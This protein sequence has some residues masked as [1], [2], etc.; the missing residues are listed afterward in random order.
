LAVFDPTHDKPLPIKARFETDENN[1]AYEAI[2]PLNFHFAAQAKAAPKVDG[3]FDDWTLSESL[4]LAANCEEHLFRH[5]N[6]G[7]W[8][9][10]EEFSG[11]LW[12]QWDVKNLYLA[13]RVH[14]SGQ[15]IAKS[16]E[17]L[18]AGDSIE[19]LIA[20]MGGRD[21]NSPYTQIAL[22]LVEGGQ[23]TVMRYQ[24]AGASGPLAKAQAVV[25]RV[26]GGYVYEA[27][28]PWAD[29]TADEAFAPK[30]GQAVTAVFGFNDKDAGTRMMSWFNHV[31][32]KDP[33]RFGQI[34]LTGPVAAGVGE[35]PVPNLVPNGNFDDA[36]L[37][38]AADLKDWR[39]TFR[40]DQQGKVCGKAY[41]SSE[42]AYSG[43]SLVIE[44]LH[45]QNHAE[46]SGFRI[47]VE[48]GQRYLLRAMI[49]APMRQPALTFG[50]RDGRGQPLTSPLAVTVLS[51]ATDFVYNGMI[52]LNTDRVTERDRFYPVAAVVTAPAT[53]KDMG[54]GFNY[55]WASGKA[56][57]DN[58]EVFALALLTE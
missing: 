43:Q 1:R 23:A 34:V 50:F 30:P 11:K 19:M 5:Q 57:F 20:P 52:M 32:Y 18:W 49:K 56:C 8:S 40:S 4:A 28:I 3:L 31:T 55:N 27:A 21:K 44:R 58:I 37:P 16:P 51:A 39:T 2:Q 47:P 15:T 10:P 13:A 46:V 14:D 26:E 12:M 9:G 29:L 24:G 54:I 17:W 25:R 42:G 33:T 48:P 38:P 22:G 53:A 45:D 41:L 36:A 6:K 7:P 35:R